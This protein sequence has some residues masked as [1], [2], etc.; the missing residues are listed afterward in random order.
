MMLRA[1]LIGLVVSLAVAVSGSPLR[2]GAWNI[3]NFGT[4]KMNI[5]LVPDIIKEVI[6]QYDLMAIQEVKDKKHGTAINDLL[7]LLNYGRDPNDKFQVKMTIPAQDKPGIDRY[8]V[9]YRPSRINIVEDITYDD[10]SNMFTHPLYELV[11][12]DMRNTGAMRYNFG[13]IVLHASPG[14]PEQLESLAD[15]SRRFLDIKNL[16]GV[17]IAG[18]LNARSW[19]DLRM[20]GNRLAD[21]DFNWLI[22]DDKNTHV[23]RQYVPSGPFDRLI[24]LEDPRGG[25]QGKLRDATPYCY[26]RDKN[27]PQIKKETQPKNPPCQ[28]RDDDIRKLVRKVSDHYPVEVKLY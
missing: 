22:S 18:D 1:V 20:E 3:E 15:E 6:E 13:M 27:I 28:P 21:S 25:F 10:K 11:L 26:D 23:N 17:L 4:R 9:F 14:K 24:A 12:K 2:L 16:P 5:P 8:A 7:N 19:R